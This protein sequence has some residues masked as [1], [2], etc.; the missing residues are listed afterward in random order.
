[1][2]KNNIGRNSSTSTRF[3][4]RE[5]RRPIYESGASVPSHCTSACFRTRRRRRRH[6]ARPAGFESK[7]GRVGT[8]SR[9]RL[10]ATPRKRRSKTTRTRVYTSQRLPPPIMT[11]MGRRAAAV[12]PLLCFPKVL[13]GLPVGRPLNLCAARQRPPSPAT[14]RRP[15]GGIKPTSER[16]SSGC[17]LRALRVCYI[18]AAVAVLPWPGSWP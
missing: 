12:C 2:H 14:R 1:M 8:R 4:L 9:P 7:P 17:P 13:A 6:G 5:T 10:V 16:A 18:V 3:W 15:P 11:T